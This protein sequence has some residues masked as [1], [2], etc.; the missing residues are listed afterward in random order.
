MGGP[1]D[2][3]RI[4]GKPILVDLMDRLAWE[5][6][7]MV[8]VAPGRRA[9]EG[10][11]RFGTAVVDAVEGEGPLRGIL[12]ALEACR[13]EWMIVVPLDMTGIEKAHLLWLITRAR[14]ERGAACVITAREERHRLPAQSGV[15]PV[16][17]VEPFPL[18][19]GHG[20]VGI[21]RGMLERGERSV[22]ALAG[23]AGTRAMGA[24]AEWDAGVWANINTPDDAAL[25]GAIT[26][27]A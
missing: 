8:V 16:A 2:R 12:T 20:M 10:A 11:E 25:A 21:V 24:P 23:A 27:T 14:K 3:L 5:G 17:R 19:I 6:P 4:G 22:R 9:V 7:T 15:Q 1:K 18:L 13:T 26:S